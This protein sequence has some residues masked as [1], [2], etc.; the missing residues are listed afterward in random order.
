MLHGDISNEVALTI[1]FRCEEN[2][3][4]FKYGEL[5]K[6][7]GKFIPFLGKVEINSRYAMLINYLYRNTDYSVE[8]IISEHLY[9]GHIKEVLDNLSFGKITPIKKDSEI[10]QRLILGDMTFYVDDND[11]R[12]SVINS[13]YAINLS[14]LQY[15]IRREH[16]NG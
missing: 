12:R 6:K 7:L 15:Y 10:S 14:D 13:P 11:Y 4:N 1:G 9:T 3:I 16:K 5:S 2:L 8:L